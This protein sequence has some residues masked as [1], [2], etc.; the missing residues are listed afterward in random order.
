MQAYG[1]VE[2]PEFENL[3]TFVM[4]A[5][6]M[7]AIPILMVPFLVPRGSPVGTAQEMGAGRA[8]LGDGQDGMPPEI[9]SC[10]R[11][12]SELSCSR[13]DIE[14]SPL[15]EVSSLSEPV[16]SSS[17]VKSSQ[18]KPVKS[19]SAAHYSKSMSQRRAEPL[20]DADVVVVRA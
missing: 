2:A 18:V 1:G 12:S 20:P 19:S 16:H 13:D 4:T 7:Q 10:C 11:A 3:E 14:V 6:L 15:G 8:I 17:Q 9:T 5:C